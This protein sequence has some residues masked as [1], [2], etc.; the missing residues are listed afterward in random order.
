MLFALWIYV[1]LSGRY[2]HIIVENEKIINICNFIDNNVVLYYVGRFGLYY[3]NWIFVI[4]AIL[5]DKLFKYK[6]VII[7]FSIFVVWI[8]KAT[9]IG[10]NF[11]NYIDFILFIVL[12]IMCKRKWYRAIIGCALTFVFAFICSMVKDL[13]ILGIDFDR[14][15]FLFGAIF[16]IDY[17]L[18]SIIYYLCI[19]YRKENEYG[20]I[21]DIFQIKQ[22]LENCFLRIRNTFTCI[23]RGNHISISK[24]DLYNVYCGFIFTFV[25]YL[26]LLIVGIVFNRWIEVTVSVAFFHIFRG[27]E[28][29]TFHAST[30]IKCFIV[31]MTSFV[32][33]MRLQLP[34]YISYVVSI[35]LALTLC[36]LMRFVF[37][38][39]RILTVISLDITKGMNVSTLKEKCLYGKLT[40]IETDILVDYYCNRY[41][42]DKIAMKYNYSTNNI[43]K[44][45]AKA[46]KRLSRNR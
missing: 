29:D 15:P 16:M 14:L 44:I 9:F 27:N 19:M 5:N 23:F 46:L 41:K 45:K 43:K 12:A 35:A 10:Y 18:M 30:D 42:L 1:A 36:M 32:V 11:I 26:S 25:T 22:T 20:T 34:L 17:I 40:T 33:I 24:I 21:W 39:I 31:S 4:Y 3:L 2:L 13:F 7:S 38:I 28:E 6:P 37:F 8:I